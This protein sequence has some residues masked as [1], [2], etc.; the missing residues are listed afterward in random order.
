MVTRNERGQRTF[1]GLAGT[2]GLL[3]ALLVTGCG[4]GGRPSSAQVLKKLESNNA[5]LLDRSFPSGTSIADAKAAV[6]QEFPRDAHVVSFIAKDVCAQM[7][8]RSGSLESSLSADSF[9]DR[10]WVEF[11]N[12]AA[13]ATAGHTVYD[14]S[15]VDTALVSLEDRNWT[16]LC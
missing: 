14:P 1:V 4:G 12:S 16:P 6:L 10:I 15:N 8:V 2:M 5:T 9:P 13:S 7:E 11:N 3:L